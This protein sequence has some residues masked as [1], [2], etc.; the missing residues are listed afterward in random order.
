VP[1][2]LENALE[3]RLNQLDRK[4]LQLL[5]STRFS[6][7]FDVRLARNALVPVLTGSGR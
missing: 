3:Q 2:A 6:K 4:L 1:A 7:K 5:V